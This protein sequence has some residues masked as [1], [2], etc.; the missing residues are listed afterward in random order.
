MIHEVPD[1]EKLFKELKIKLKLVQ[2][3]SET[4]W[5]ET[6][7]L[8]NGKYVPYKYEW[9]FKTGGMKKISEYADGVGPWKPMIV[10]NNSTPEKLIFTILVKEA[11][12]AGLEVHPY[13]FRLDKGRIPKYAKDFE[14]MVEI[15][16][17]KADVDGI[18]TDFP[19]RAVN[20]LKNRK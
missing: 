12:T 6:M 14:D 18:F 10:D 17:F 4:S 5:R 9:M 11:H 8:E 16:L 1:E 3:I 20:Y 7:I 13:T 19:D 2:L 15:F